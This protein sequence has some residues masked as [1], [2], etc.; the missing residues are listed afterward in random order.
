MARRAFARLLRLFGI[1]EQPAAWLLLLGGIL[2]LVGVLMDVI[3]TG[4]A[5]AATIL[6]ACD[7]IVGGFSAVQGAHD[8]DE[9]R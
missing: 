3:V 7:L 8:D 9:R 6:V 2:T 1:I 5:K 4:N